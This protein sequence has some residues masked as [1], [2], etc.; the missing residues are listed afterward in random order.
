M[1]RD[2]FIK[3]TVYIA[4]NDRATKDRLS[5]TVRINPAR[6][7]LAKFEA[8]PE[9]LW[10]TQTYRKAEQRCAYGHCGVD[11]ESP[12]GYLTF[13]EEA[14]A[15]TSLL[16]FPDTI[17]DGA[18]PLYRQETPKQRILAALRGDRGA[19]IERGVL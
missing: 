13:P 17:N 14:Q 2:S 6:N 3:D 1:R 19:R 10:C 5:A 12:E 18:N 15:L 7:F 4:A 9:S 16:G 8:I 11:G